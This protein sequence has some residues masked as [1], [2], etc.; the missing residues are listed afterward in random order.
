MPDPYVLPGQIIAGPDGNLWF[1]GI[2]YNNFTT[3]RPSGS[4]G[5]LTPGKQITLFPLP[6]PNTYPTAITFTSDGTLWFL[7]F[8]G[9][10]PLAPIG[11]TVRHFSS[12][13]PQ[14]GRMTPDGHFSFFS[15][16][17]NDIYLTAIAAG[18][19]GNVWLAEN[20]NNNGA[21]SMHMLA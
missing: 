3:T 20:D 18:S 8:Q 14:I 11:D 12:V 21:T 1:P 13:T 4:I 7:A 17:S 2:A 6:T 19:D 15:L 10:G 16:P 9:S 5:R